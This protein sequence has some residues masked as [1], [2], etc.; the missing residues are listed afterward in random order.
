MPAQERIRGRRLQYTR[1]LVLRQQP[2]CAHCM[3]RGIVTEA[4][5]VDH[6]VALVNGGEDAIDN[7]QGL[8]VPC[9]EQKTRADLG[10][11]TKGCDANGIPL[12][13]WK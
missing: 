4:T 1:A 5:V 6:V 11:R 8:C 12:A 2:L 10:Q 3:A 9:H 7:M 13:G